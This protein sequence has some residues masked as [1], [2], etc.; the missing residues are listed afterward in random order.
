MAQADVH[1]VSKGF[2]AET[3]SGNVHYGHEVQGLLFVIL[4]VGT[5]LCITSVVLRA[6][7]RT[8]RNPV[9][10]DSQPGSWGAVLNVY[11]KYGHGTV[12]VVSDSDE[13]DSEYGTDDS[14][15]FVE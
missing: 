10:S 7:A 8:E 13:T 9:E 12:S 14:M 4:V 2:E 6:V 3:E 11:G 1:V 5:V 15:E